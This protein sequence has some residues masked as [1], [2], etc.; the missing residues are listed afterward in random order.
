[1]NANPDAYNVEES[2]E[3]KSNLSD[4][5]IYDFLINFSNNRQIADLTEI[6]VKG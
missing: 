4:N 5:Q 2:N 3:K 6:D 1:M